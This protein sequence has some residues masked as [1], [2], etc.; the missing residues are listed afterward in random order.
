MAKKVKA[1]ADHDSTTEEERTNARAR[2]Q[3]I[4]QT[5]EITERDIEQEELEPDLPMDATP[6]QIWDSILVQMGIPE[7]EFHKLLG[8]SVSS[9]LGKVWFVGELLKSEKSHALLGKAIT[10]AALRLIRKGTP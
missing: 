8:S 3:E 4:M 6:D 2:L 10:D 5:Y 1:L 7:E 9:L